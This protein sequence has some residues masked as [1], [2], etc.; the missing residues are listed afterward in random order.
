[1]RILKSILVFLN[2]L[3]L[4]PFATFAQSRWMPGGSVY[5]SA[6]TIRT[7]QQRDQA[8][9]KL[10]LS[11]H[12]IAHWDHAKSMAIRAYLY[13]YCWEQ[14]RKYMQESNID[15]KWL[16]VYQQYTYLQT[17]L[18]Q[19]LQPTVQKIRVIMDDKNISFPII[20]SHLQSNDP[21]LL[22]YYGTIP[23]RY[24][25]TVFFADVE[26]VRDWL[27]RYKTAN[28]S[29]PI[30][31]S[32]LITYKFIPS[33]VMLSSKK[34]I[35]RAY[36]LPDI[37]PYVTLPPQKYILV[38]PMYVLLYQAQFKDNIEY[39]STLDA[40]RN[41]VRTYDFSTRA[42]IKKT[43]LQFN[44]EGAWWKVTIPMDDN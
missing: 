33:D 34:I 23:Q 31:L 39:I 13:Q 30:S 8:R 40:L 44:G 6:Q 26:I 2:F 9:E 19:S 29:Y 42:K 37:V 16:K 18:Y 5:F 35:Y 25:D 3:M 24:V 7:T 41:K 10:N 32:D 4:L 21:T 15:W 14:A 43:P 11:I 28:D 27:R 1:M 12:Q 17:Q 38:E 22:Y 36:N 20:L